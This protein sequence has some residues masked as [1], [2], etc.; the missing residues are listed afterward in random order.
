[1]GPPAFHLLAKPTGATCN[2]DCAYCFF[3][4]KEMLYPGS[5]FRMADELLETYIRQLIEAHRA[6]H[7]D[8]RLAGRRADAD[9]RR[10]L[11]AGHRLRREVPP[12]R[13][14]DRV[15]HPDQRDAHRR[16]IGGVLQGARLPRRDQH[17]RAAR[18]CTTRTAWT[19]AARRRSSGSCRGLETPAG[20]RCRVQHADH[21]PPRQRRPPGSR[22]IA[23]CATSCGSRFI[24]FIPIIERLPAPRIDVPLDQLGLSPGLA[25]D[26]P[27]RSWRDRPLYRQ[28]GEPG[29]RPVRDRRP[30]RV[31]PER[32]V[33]G[34]GPPG[35]R[36][37]VRPDVRRGPGQ[38]VRRAADAV[39][40]LRRRAATALAMEHNG[41][42]YSCDHFVEEGVQAR[43]HHRD[44]DGGAGGLRAQRRFGHDK[45]DCLPRLLPRLRRP[46]RLPWRLPQGPLHRDARR[47]ARAQLP[48]RGVQGVLRSRRPADADD[49]RAAPP[50]PSAV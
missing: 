44:A 12:A 10:L 23:S 1:M 22:S 39:H 17:R 41:D 21:A 8:D 6:P 40:P 24:Q 5:R 15:H 32:R 49:V 28:E 45:L 3:L 27:W 38:L 43:Q 2:L 14:D 50:R 46:V 48:V 26:A 34:V 9:G 37:G 31:V 16:R 33:R 11:P 19:G 36:R 18:R 42:L 30:V 13:D 20:A 25:H 7:V 4:S 47:R 29:H 35:H